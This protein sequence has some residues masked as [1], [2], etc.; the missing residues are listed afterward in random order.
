VGVVVLLMLKR[1]RQ[2]DCKFKA[3]LGY[4]DKHCFKTTELF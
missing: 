2:E 1:L 3:S 4:I